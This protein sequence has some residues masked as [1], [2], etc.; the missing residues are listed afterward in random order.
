MN[1]R[2]LAERLRSIEESPAQLQIDGTP[3][4]EECGEMP[5]P[6]AMIQHAPSQQDNVSMSV[7][8][9]G[10]GAGG[11]KDLMDILRNIEKGAEHGTAPMTSPAHTAEPEIKVLDDL[12]SADPETSIAGGAGDETVAGE[13]SEQTVIGHDVDDDKEHD[14]QN[15]PHRVT[16]NVDTITRH[17]DDLLSKGD[18][19]R[20]KVNGG[21][22]PLQEGLVERLQ[23]LYDS[24][25]EAEGD[26]RTMSR[27][28]KGVMKYGKD[29]M[30]AL[31]KAGKEGK[32]LDKVRDKYNKYDEAYNPNSA[33]AEHRRKM[34]KHTHDTLKA[35]AEK[36]GA[37]DADKARYKR[38]QD[39]KEAMRDEYN[40]RMER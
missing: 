5:M 29:G 27:A 6:T 22:N 19:K 26:K 17:G 31:A 16:Y 4:V 25:K 28:A 8:M 1:F 2:D 20:L 34:D 11:I 21:E 33:S 35:A 38:Y 36:E 13:G 9:N 14:I 30:K 10:Q 37:T 18:V 7:N 3:P 24:I 40:A 32:D 12:L 39:R 15:R 23:S